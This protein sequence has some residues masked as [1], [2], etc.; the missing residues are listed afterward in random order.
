MAKRQVQ[1]AVID[2]L[3]GWICL[4][5]RPRRELPIYVN[6]PDLPPAASPPAALAAK[7][8]AQSKDD[9]GVAGRRVVVGGRI[10][11]VVQYF[12]GVSGLESRQHRVRNEIFGF[13]P[14]MAPVR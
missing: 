4:R 7:S 12:D 5:R 6:T 2:S 3:P 13:R 11:I 14:K 1:I 8:P 10:A 9:G